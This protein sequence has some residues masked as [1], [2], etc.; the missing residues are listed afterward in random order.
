MKREIERERQREREDSKIV[1]IKRYSNM[2]WK[3]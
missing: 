1:Q 3:K 2:K